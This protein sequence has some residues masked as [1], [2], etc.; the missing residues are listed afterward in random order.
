[1]SNY[2]KRL[3]RAVLGQDH[4]LQDLRDF[5]RRY[6]LL[7]FDDP[8]P[9]SRRL[10]AERFRYLLEEATEFNDAPTLELMADA[11][12]DVVYIAKGT[13]VMMGLPWEE[14]WA[15]VQRA[16][17]EKEPA[18]TAR[19]PRDVV[20][21]AGWVP[22]MGDRILT[23]AGSYWSGVDVNDTSE[24]YFFLRTQRR[25]YPEFAEVQP[26]PMFHLQDNNVPD[27][28]AREQS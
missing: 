5:N 17:M 12:I 26:F 25:D 28:F 8:G 14:L 21:P 19:S 24:E 7:A 1:V 9:L 16:N 23:D 3:W 4:E 22:P 18:S 2:L 27:P 11:L 6:N 20:K 10:H 15:D 13:A